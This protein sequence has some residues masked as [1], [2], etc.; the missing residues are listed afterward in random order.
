MGLENGYGCTVNGA[1]VPV[2]CSAHH[3]AATVPSLPILTEVM[4][5]LDQ[6]AQRPFGDSC[7]DLCRQKLLAASGG[8]IAASIG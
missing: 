1:S 7:H 6:P 5:K 4:R 2:H 8:A 3:T